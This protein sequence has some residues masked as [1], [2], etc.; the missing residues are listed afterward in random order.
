MVI[1]ISES[2]VKYKIV[3]MRLMPS[4]Q[5][6]RRGKQDMMITYEMDGAIRD[7]VTVPSEDAT[8]AAAKVAVE[9][10]IKEKLKFIGLE[11]AVTR[12]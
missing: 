6:D 1:E 3:D 5:T 8:P 2:D 9:N 7:F 10:H 4:M 11:G 12:G